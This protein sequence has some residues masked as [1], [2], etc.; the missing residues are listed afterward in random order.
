MTDTERCELS[1]RLRGL[2]TELYVES[3]EPSAAET[4]VSAIE[5]IRRIVRSVHRRIDRIALCMFVIAEL[6]R[7][8]RADPA[9][10]VRQAAEEA[11]DELSR[12]NRPE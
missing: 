6:I 5:E 3:R 1:R 10:R 9:P 2:A 4:R 12:L 8:W 11:L 7:T